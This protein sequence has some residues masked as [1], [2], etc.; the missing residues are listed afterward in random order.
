[1]VVL[2]TKI[3]SKF[4]KLSGTILSFRYYLLQMLRVKALT[5]NVPT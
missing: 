4:R 3:D 1:M 2:A 5:F